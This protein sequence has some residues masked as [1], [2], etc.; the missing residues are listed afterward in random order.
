MSYEYDEQSGAYLRS[1]PWGE[2]ILADGDRVTADAVLVI[3]AAWEMGKIG[4]GSHAPDPIVD[5]VDAEGTFHYLCRA[6]VG[7]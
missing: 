7:S 6:A 1:Q 3:A 2:H 5:I 4:S